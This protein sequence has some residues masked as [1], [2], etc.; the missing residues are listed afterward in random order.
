MVLKRIRCPKCGNIIEIEYTGENDQ[1]VVCNKCGSRF[2]LRNKPKVENEKREEPFKRDSREKEKK[3]RFFDSLGDPDN[4]INIFEKDNKIKISSEMLVST[5]PTAE[6]KKILKYLGIVSG[7]VI[8]GA[9]VFKDLF[10]GV[11]DIIGG[12]ARAYEE[13]IKRGKEIAINEMVKEAKKLGASAILSVA[14]DY[15][16]I[17]EWGCL[18]MVCVSGTAVVVGEED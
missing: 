13:E 17:R 1:R 10:A 9:N 3:T 14:L 16:T 2:I 15:E 5:T 12:R 11:R 6:G 7:E 18:L 4:P 8:M